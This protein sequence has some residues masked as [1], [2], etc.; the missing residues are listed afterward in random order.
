MWHNKNLH[1]FYRKLINALADQRWNSEDASATSEET[2]NN[3]SKEI[4]ISVLENLDWQWK[5]SRA[6]K[7]FFLDAAKG[8][9]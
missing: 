8:E 5:G 9:I 1:R 4:N 7:R 6:S 3:T 2:E